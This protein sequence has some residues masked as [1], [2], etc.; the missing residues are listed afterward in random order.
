MIKNFQLIRNVGQFNSVDAGR[1][2]D[3]SKLTLIYGDN[4]RGK[5]TLAEVLQSLAENDP[6]FITRRKR[7]NAS[8]DPHIV[9]QLDDDSKPLLFQNGTWSRTLTS[10]AVFNDA[11]V[12]RNVHSGRGITPQQ[13]QHLH[14]LVLGPT[15][16]TLSK[17]LDEI[18]S[19]INRH[20][21]ELDVKAAAIPERD[22]GTLSIRDF[23]DLTE[24]PEIDRAIRAATDNLEASR[25]QKEITDAQP[26]KTLRLSDFSL[27]AIEQVLQ[28]DLENLESVA[29]QRV[30]NH[31]ATLGN[32]GEKWVSDGMKLIP[33]ESG[34]STCPFCA[35]DL[36]GTILQH[37]KAYFS[38]AYAQLKQK[39][40]GMLEQTGSEHGE[41]AREKFESELRNAEA[42]RQ[43]WTRFSKIGDFNLDVS[44]ILQSWRAARDSITELLR[45]KQSAPLEK[46]EVTDHTKKLLDTYGNH[47]ATIAKVNQQL[48]V[49]NQA[50][51]EVKE[52]VASTNERELSELL[53]RLKLT[54]RRYT[55]EVSASCDAYMQEIA[56]KAATEKART[57]KQKQ[58]DEHRESAF[59]KY[60]LSVNQYLEKFGAE[61]KLSELRHANLGNSSTSTYSAQIG[62]A[63]IPIGVSNSKPD[64][65]SYGDVLSGGDR[66]A[67]D[68]AFF[69]AS[70]EER[71]GL[72]HTVVVVDDPVSSSD[73]HRSLATAQEIRKLADRVGQVIVLS[74][75]KLFLCQI[76]EGAGLKNCASLEIIRSGDG[77]ALR[78]WDMKADSRTEHDRRNRAFME[79]R[80][81]GSGDKR[82]VARDIRLH[83]EGFLRVACPDDFHV[84]DSLGNKF[85]S[86]CEERLKKGEQILS[87]AKLQEL[88]DILDYAHR[89][90][91]DTNPAWAKEQI[92]DGELSHYVRLTLD[93]CKV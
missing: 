33:S 12:D 84:G 17:E 55:P 6:S 39:V 65:P 13:R 66:N 42:L 15:A 88:C 18:R 29:L 9:L 10:L 91:H 30:Q 7:A 5:T 11:F 73:D 68:L 83:L 41:G 25:S 3:L 75:R 4:G 76:G 21:Q 74:H 82:E 46:I 80:E 59:K 72:E 34:K 92:N 36:E 57:E 67:L 22:R 85:I 87:K 32:G 58:L 81:K 51:K 28:A 71:P 16:V 53:E 86:Q 69:L 63:S 78:K 64:E 48:Q 93:F 38:D 35:R 23:C 20:N 62:D 49:A 79:Y 77:S 40:T 60:Q 45:Q 24:L 61:F 56:A 89:F 8:G 19:A 37:Y 52:Q 90:H 44:E 26:F 2:L 14:G 50:I 31:L 27:S 43:F 54:Q 1:N 47:V 70:L